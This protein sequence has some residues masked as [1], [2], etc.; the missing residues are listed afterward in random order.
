MEDSSYHE[1][2][3]LFQE[4]KQTSQESVPS[5][6]NNSVILWYPEDWEWS[7]QRSNGCT[8][9]HKRLW[10]GWDLSDSLNSF[11]VA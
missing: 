4:K 9:S 3:I 10:K 11:S 6:L 5:N 1:E 8:V 7:T 2:F